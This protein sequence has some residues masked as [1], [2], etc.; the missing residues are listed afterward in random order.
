MFELLI[1][2]LTSSFSSPD[3]EVTIL[4]RGNGETLPRQL[5]LMY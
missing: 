2:H 1:K 3:S 4:S 5:A